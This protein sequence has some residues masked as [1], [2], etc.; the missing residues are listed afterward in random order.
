MAA[1]R[2]AVTSIDRTLKE[3]VSGCLGVLRYFRHFRHFWRGVC[4]RCGTRWEVCP[5][6]VRAVRKVGPGGLRK[7]C[8][9][10]KGNERSR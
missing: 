7:G 9:V 1:G 5:R 2:K 4:T 3:E 6:K 8:G 10:S